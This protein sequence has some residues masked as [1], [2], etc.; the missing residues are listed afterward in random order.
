MTVSLT[1]SNTLDGATV[2]DALAGGGTGVDL[3]SVTNG[4]YSDVGIGTNVGQRD[5]YVYH[6]AVADPITDTK[7]F[8]QQYLTD[9]I[10]PH[11]YGGPGTSSP[12]L[13]FGRIRTMGDDSLNSKD[14]ADGASEGLW[15]DMDSDVAEVNQF[16][17]ATNG[18]DGNA[19]ALGN[20]SVAK[21]GDDGEVHGIGLANAIVIKAAAMVYDSGG[22]TQPS[23][24]ADGVIGLVAGGDVGETAAEAGDNAHIKLR[25][26]LKTSFA[27]G[28]IHQFE[29]VLAYSFTA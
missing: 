28:G 21:Y 10:A 29:Y 20:L 6:D 12:T 7:T 5:L 8:I 23:A 25:M 22:E 2:S 11:T 4:S 19:E 18:F 9:L 27:T 1:V 26:Y 17:Y 13:D 24:P 15:I 3:G 14:N 16:D